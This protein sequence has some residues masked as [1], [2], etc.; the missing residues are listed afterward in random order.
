MAVAA[1][2]ATGWNGSGSARTSLRSASRTAGVAEEGPVAAYVAASGSVAHAAAGGGFA[3]NVPAERFVR[4]WDR[5]AGTAALF[6]V[7]GGNARRRAVTTG[8]VQGENVEIAAGLNAG[9]RVVIRGGFTLRDGD[10]VRT[11]AAGL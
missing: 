9:E 5:E 10:A 1:A 11:A 4:A 2:S 7:E 8:S 6:V 3:D